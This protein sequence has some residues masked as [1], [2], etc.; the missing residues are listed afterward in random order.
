[1]LCFFDSRGGGCVSSD[2]FTKNDAE[3]DFFA[4][5]QRDSTVP[6][7]EQIFAAPAI[8]MEAADEEDIR[9][10]GRQRMQ[11]SLGDAA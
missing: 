4:G 5:P 3:G 1:M 2:V 6:V 7:L 11:F 8:F 9:M 10:I